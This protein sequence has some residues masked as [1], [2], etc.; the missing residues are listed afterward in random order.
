MNLELVRIDSAG[1]LER[2][3]VVL[4]ATVDTDV[5]EYAVFRCEQAEMP[6][7]VYV[8]PIPNAYWFPARKLKAND[9]VVLYSKA[10]AL[11]EKR[12]EG[13]SASSYFFYW[14][15]DS[16]LW[17]AQM[18]PVLVETSNWIFG[19]PAQPMKRPAR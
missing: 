8:G 14:N 19:K 1:D 15:S 3:R 18:V 6:D 13:R 10:G 16:T 5:G 7:D 2:E 11:S 4:R 9:W 17:L 12:G